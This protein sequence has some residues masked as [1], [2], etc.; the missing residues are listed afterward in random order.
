MRSRSL[1]YYLR[2]IPPLSCRNAKA[3][4]TG[5]ARIAHLPISALPSH[6][7]VNGD[8]TS[9]FEPSDFEVADGSYFPG[10]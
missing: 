3:S 1:G 7:W 4:E 10:I 9:Q 2:N 6:L 8:L 5:M